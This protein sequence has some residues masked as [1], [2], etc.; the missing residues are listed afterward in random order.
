MKIKIIVSSCI[1]VF[2]IL[3]LVWINAKT[4]VF[5]DNPYNDLIIKYSTQYGV[6]ASLVKAL[7]K[8]E[9]NL[10]PKA[11]SPK[12]AVGLMQIMPKT[13][14][15]IAER[16][17]MNIDSDSLK[18]P[19]INIMFGVYYLKQLLSYYNS[20]LILSLAAYN[21][22]IGNV[23]VWTAQNPGISKTISKIPFKETRRHVRGII[24]AYKIYKVKEK[25]KL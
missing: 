11:V 2:F 16:F 25:L 10:N 22:G 15:E 13:A 9:S 8:R 4:G 6:D 12:G 5:S 19:E 14:G 3:C 7:I 20:N 18:D 21:A 24:F 17:Q 1:A 23:E